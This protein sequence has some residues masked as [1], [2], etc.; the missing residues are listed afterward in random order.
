MDMSSRRLLLHAA[1]AIVVACS[2]VSAFAQVYPD[3]AVK[4][5]VPFAAGGPTD[6]VARVIAEGLSE[7]LKQ[8]F[9]VENR[10]GAGGAIGTDVLAKAKPDGYTLGVT[11]TG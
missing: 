10:A 6:V 2:T 4:I 8:P 5:V 1:A 7:E 11:G 3:K 9:I